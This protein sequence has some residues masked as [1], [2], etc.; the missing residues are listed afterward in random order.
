MCTS[1]RELEKKMT[2]QRQQ[3]DSSFNRWV[4]GVNLGHS[5]SFEEAFWHWYHHGG[6]DAFNKRWNRGEFRIA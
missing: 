1:A 3:V 5:P 6:R 4:A 2:L